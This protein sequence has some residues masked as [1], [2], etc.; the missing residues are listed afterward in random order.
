MSDFRELLNQE[1]A[2]LAAKAEQ[3]ELPD[4]MRYQLKKE[5]VALERS[6]ELGNYDEKYEKVSHY[7][8]WCLR[9]PF[10]KKTEDTL[11]LTQAQEIFNQHHF[12][13]QEVKNRFLEYLAVLNLQKNNFQDE[14]FSAPILLL[15]GLVGTGKTTFAYSLAEALGRKLVRI[16]FGGMGS[17]KE[18][19]GNSRL[20]LGSEPGKVLKGVCS[21]GVMN[22]IILLDEIDRNVDEA[23]MDIM[24]VLVEL[25]DP[26]QN[27]AFTDDYI[28]YPID[29]SQAIFLATANNTRKIATAVMDRMEKID[30]PSYTD[31]EKIAIAKKYVMPRVLKEVG[32]KPGQFTIR[33]EMWLKMVRPLGFDAGIR[34]LQRTIQG[35]AR[36]A[37]RI[38][39]E[40]KY[41]KVEIGPDNYKIFLPSY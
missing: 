37:A 32:L 4:E 27:H 7:I 35:A 41:D 17:A 13:M 16:P 40:G 36:K 29:L 9:I 12:G 14:K 10:G 38:I 1:I 33:E 26:A 2:A 28:N 19:R 34:T 25:L 30:M 23:N 20:L 3:A 39:V 18:L 15:V 11:D 22:P 5:I 6:V 21:A 31:E 24:G 8:D